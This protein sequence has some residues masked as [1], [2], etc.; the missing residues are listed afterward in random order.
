M[1]N[2]SAKMLL[3]QLCATLRPCFF[4]ILACCYLVGLP[5]EAQAPPVPLP[6]L[7]PP[8][9]LGARPP[10]PP[11]ARICRL[12]AGWAVLSVPLTRL[13]GLSGLSHQLYRQTPEGFLPVDPA[14]SPLDPRLAYWT[15]SEHPQTLSYWGSAASEAGGPMRLFQG[16]NLL[17]CP[18]DKPL[19]LSELWLTGPESEGRLVARTAF[20]VSPDSPF[21]P[22][23]LDLSDSGSVL[24][25]GQGLW[26]YLYGPA[27]LSDQGR[28]GQGNHSAP[29][30]AM[31]SRPVPDPLQQGLVSGRVEDPDGNPVPSARVRLGQ[32]AALS[33]ADG[34][35]YL[36]HLPA[37]PHLVEVE[38]T[39]FR[40]ASGSLTVRPGQISRLLTTLEPLH[41]PASRKVRVYLTA[42]PFQMQGRRWWVHK[43]L[44]WQVGNYHR[45]DSNTWYIDAP[46]RL[47]DWGE[48]P[49]GGR[50]R[51]E[52][53]WTDGR[54][55]RFTSWDRRV[56]RDWQQEYFYSPWD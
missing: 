4:Y 7:V 26:V 19:A 20:V 53:T 43:I 55:Q 18:C 15:Y 27:D 2:L 25:P 39:G 48:A 8:P 42:Y 54:N 21:A 47:L 46:S 38:A 17:G 28:L 32:Q 36:P 50:I 34:R 23:E 51:V 29:L 5:A 41:P 40:S 30:P 31:V 56:R 33:G 24:S 22:K 52:I 11:G 49:L 12:P 37:G 6:P 10:A 44:V 45:R 14:A 1:E 35:F 13:D 3:L 9:V 16:W